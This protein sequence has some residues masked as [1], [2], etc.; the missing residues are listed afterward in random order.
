VGEWSVVMDTVRDHGS[1]GRSSCLLILPWLHLDRC[2]VV[3]VVVVRIVVIGL[4]VVHAVCSWTSVP[5][6]PATFSLH[7]DTVAVFD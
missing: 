7:I 6:F 5:C 4:V 3:S 1:V 2:V